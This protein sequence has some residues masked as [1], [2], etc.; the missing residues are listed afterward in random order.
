M[1]TGALADATK[2]AILIAGNEIAREVID[3]GTSVAVSRVLVLPEI[4]LPS[5][6]MVAAVGLNADGSALMP[7]DASGLLLHELKEV[8]RG[9]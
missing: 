1:F 2:E 8:L 3:N 4:V 6:R 9:R 5:A 7:W